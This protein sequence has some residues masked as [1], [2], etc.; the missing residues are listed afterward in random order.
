ME[1]QV[2]GKKVSWELWLL[3][4][5]LLVFRPIGSLWGWPR[6]DASQALGNTAHDKLLRFPG[7]VHVSQEASVRRDANGE[8]Y[9]I[10]HVFSRVKCLAPLQAPGSGLWNT[11][12]TKPSAHTFC[13][14][15][16]SQKMEISCSLL[17]CPIYTKSLRGVKYGHLWTRGCCSSFVSWC[18]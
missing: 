10:K 1:T 13:L 5:S 17:T 3:S 8:A 14:L 4:P 15:N 9:D 7:P 11:L 2:P 16:I 12:S 6:K 18:W